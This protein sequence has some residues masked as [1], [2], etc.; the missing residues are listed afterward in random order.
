MGIIGSNIVD[1][2][3]TV[4][5]IVDDLKAGT[6]VPRMTVKGRLGLDELLRE[7]GVEVVDWCGF[8]KIDAQEKN[9]SRRRSELQPREKITNRLEMVQIAQS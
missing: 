4:Y 1:A 3:D 8:E 2:K 7:R 6:V 9:L 5:S